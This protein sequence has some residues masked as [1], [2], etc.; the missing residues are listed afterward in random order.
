MVLVT[1][2]YLSKILF[3]AYLSWFTTQ[4]G[5]NNLLWWQK[6]IYLVK[7][8]GETC[9]GDTVNCDII[10]Q[11]GIQRTLFFSIDL[12]SVY[13]VCR[14]FYCPPLVKLPTN[15]AVDVSRWDIPLMQIAIYLFHLIPLSMLL[16]S[17]FTPWPLQQCKYKRVF[18]DVWASVCSQLCLF[19]LTQWGRRKKYWWLE[20]FSCLR[21]EY[22]RWKYLVIHFR[23]CAFFCSKG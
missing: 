10:A 21:R 19:L 11:F 17:D 2:V 18:R 13:H 8:F 5:C 7:L 1:E 9:Q 15:M 3:Q 16:F 23:M 14:T 4:A 6:A 20:N 12:A 22:R